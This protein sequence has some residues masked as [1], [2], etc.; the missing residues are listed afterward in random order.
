M[1]N[2]VP[3][4]V[5][6]PYNKQSVSIVKIKYQHDPGSIRHTSLRANITRDPQIDNH[7]ILWRLRQ[8]QAAQHRDTFARVKFPRDLPQTWPQVGQWECALGD[9]LG[10]AV[11]SIFPRLQSL[12]GLDVV[13][14][15]EMNNKLRISGICAA[16]GERIGCEKS[17]H[18]QEYVMVFN[19]SEW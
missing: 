5:L 4:L 18:I 8:L 17:W 10:I 9:T 7:I 6:R 14:Q 19:K 15:T 11:L 12:L 3:L 2:H 16:E 1:R 13:S